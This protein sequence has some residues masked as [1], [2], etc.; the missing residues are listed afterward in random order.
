MSKPNEPLQVD[1][2]ELRVAAEQLDGQASSFAEKHQSAHARV[3][4]TALGSGQ[5]AAALPQMLSS[6]EEQGV[7]FGA[8]F[9][10]H[11]EGHRQAAAGYDTTDE[12]AAAG[13]DDAGSEL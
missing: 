1:P 6:W 10:R 5:A 11:S 13:I 8:Q 4:G 2:A 12:T 3:G 9:A 7:Q